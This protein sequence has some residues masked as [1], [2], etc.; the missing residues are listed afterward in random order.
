MRRFSTSLQRSTSSPGLRSP[1]GSVPGTHPHPESLHP[2]E[3]SLLHATRL[4]NISAL[5]QAIQQADVHLPKPVSLAFALEVV[6]RIPRVFQYVSPQAANY[7]LRHCLQ[8]AGTLDPGDWM[9]L[10]DR[11]RRVCPVFIEPELQRM[12]LRALGIDRVRLFMAGPRWLSESQLPQ[13]SGARPAR[14]AGSAFWQLPLE[15]Q[16]AIFEWVIPE[17]SA[18]HYLASVHAHGTKLMTVCRSLSALIEPRLEEARWRWSGQWTRADCLSGSPQ[19]AVARFQQQC[20]DATGWMRGR[21]WNS[22]SRE[23]WASWHALKA[24]LEQRLMQLAC[25]MGLLADPQQVRAGM[26]GLFDA[27]KSM[28]W[29]W[30][31]VQRAE[32]AYVLGLTLCLAHEGQA[33]SGEYRKSLEAL[34]TCDTTRV[35]GA[36]KGRL[37]FYLRSG[38]PEA[39][40]TPWDGVDDADAS[41]DERLRQYQRTFDTLSDGQRLHELEHISP[42]AGWSL[43][44]LAV[45]C[46][47]H[48]LSQAE[49]GGLVCSAKW[50]AFAA[51]QLHNFLTELDGIWPYDIALPTV[52]LF[53]RVPPDLMRWA[54]QTLPSDVR[55]DLLHRPVSFAP[56][57][58]CLQLALL[59]DFVFD[60]AIA[61]STRLECLRR[62]C[63]RAPR[64]KAQMQAVAASWQPLSAPPVLACSPHLEDGSAAFEKQLHSGRHALLSADVQTPL[65]LLKDL[66]QQAAGPRD[67]D[68]AMV[69]VRQ[70]VPAPLDIHFLAWLLERLVVV[71]QGR[72]ELGKEIR[73]QFGQELAVRPENE[74]I[75]L[76]E[77]LDQACTMVTT[78]FAISLWT[79]L[80]VHWQGAGGGPMAGPIVSARLLGVQRRC[81]R[82]LRQQHERSLISIA[83]VWRTL[84][85]WARL[86]APHQAMSG[87]LEAIAQW[88]RSL[89]DTAGGGA[90]PRS[91]EV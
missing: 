66:L 45:V 14:G 89:E 41:T 2:Q 51:E 42:R 90:S 28:D 47:T 57:G 85:E 48:Q 73:R 80:T 38:Q 30:S 52:A 76:L 87:V 33:S 3:R 75:F 53:E 16:L 61:E 78:P 6:E 18:A 55:E 29:M 22:F 7:L 70:C 39:V 25:A 19:Q 59:C 46:T 68:A 43:S 58:Q 12:L 81:L 1:D 36:A 20:L 13:N 15:L 56:S 54:F 11:L 31:A 91:G 44:W 17:P 82:E 35:L 83:D 37:D 5:L 74:Q 4:G 77:R 26:V 9:V 8:W 62:W 64:L 79:D 67:F 40:V 65:A 50:W 27:L 71:C 49:R 10:L 69:L 23:E 24:E 86:L 88:M 32:L 72:S 60:A 63:W 34:I 21:P 84:D